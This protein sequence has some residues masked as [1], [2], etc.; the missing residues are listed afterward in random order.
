MSDGAASLDAPRA[1]LFDLDC[2]LLDIN[3]LRT[4][5]WWRAL[6]EAG[7]GVPMSAIHHLIGMGSTEM[8]TELLGR[9][10]RYLAR[11]N[12]FGPSARAA[13]WCWLSPQLRRTSS[14]R[15]LRRSAVMMPLTCCSTESRERRSRHPTCFRSR[16][17]VP[18]SNDRRLSRGAIASGMSL[19]PTAAGVRR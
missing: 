13:R 6:T 16:W 17:I 2:T 4:L 19:Q 15:S 12:W 5:A 7:N 1:V 8:V 10:D 18:R 9:Y 11:P 3:S 14:M